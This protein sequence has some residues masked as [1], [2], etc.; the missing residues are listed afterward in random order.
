MSPHILP[1]PGNSP[2]APETQSE[3]LGMLEQGQIVGLPTETC[4][5][6]AVRADKPEALQALSELKGRDAS[7]TFTWHVG[8]AQAALD[9]ALW[10]ALTKRL[11]DAFWPG[12]L[13]L[14]L[15]MDPEQ[16]RARGLEGIVHE[17]N[18][19]IRLPRHGATQELLAKAPFP[20]VMSSANSTGETPLT[21]ANE[22]AAVFGQKIAAVANGDATELGGSSTILALQPGRFELL[23]GGRISLEDLQSKA[24]LRLLFVCTGNTCR[25]P[26]AEGIARQRI[27]KALGTTESGLQAFGF[28]ASSAG[29][30]AGVNSPVSQ[31]S[32]DVLLD[33]GIDITKHAST[34]SSTA[35]SRGVDLAYGLTESHVEALRA[36]MSPEQSRQVHLLSPSGHSISDPIGGTLELYSDTRDEISQAINERMAQWV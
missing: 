24:G 11:T 26:M 12:P 30:F 31:E 2:V 10:P 29:V 22:V 25:S 34:L 35:L 33:W 9:V 16:A 20:I 18:V 8:H 23:R 21:K 1:F 7:Q 6:L 27:A 17:G 14:V 32:V 13:T 19:G 15:P 5:G 4:Y 36:T 3:L 28:R